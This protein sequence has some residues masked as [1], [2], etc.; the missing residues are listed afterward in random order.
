MFSSSNP[1]LT[2]EDVFTRGGA[3]AAGEA[4]TVEALEEAYAAPSYKRPVITAMTLDDVVM[5]TGLL[6][7]VALVT[8]AVAWMLDLGYGVAIGAMLVGLG[9]GLANTFKRTVSPALVLAYA[10]V[11][12]V[13]L[14]SFT[15]VLNMIYPGIGVQAVLATAA[16]FVTMLALYRS[17]R[18]RVTPRFTK[19]LVGVGAGY[20]VFLAVN[21]LLTF[22]GGGFDLWNTGGGSI[23]L[24]LAV[25][26]LGVG[27]G[28]LFLVLD[29][30]QIEKA[31]AAGVPESESWRAAFGLLVTLVWIYI[32]MLRLI[33]IL[34]GD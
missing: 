21:L 15:H 34:R 23:V 16:A 10:A 5:K 12:G 27:L 7:V 3:V 8:G 4:A 28:C 14:G 6:V 13:F 20:V 32:E 29:F 18:I 31:V 22:M 2:R 19:I 24:P 33:A 9:L 1:V 30:D 11:E 17:G 25:S 26:L